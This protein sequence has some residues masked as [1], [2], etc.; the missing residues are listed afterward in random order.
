MRQP[1]THDRLAWSSPTPLVVSKLTPQKHLDIVAA[2][3]RLAL[4]S[5]KKAPRYMQLAKH[6]EEMAKVAEVTI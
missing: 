3:H 6:H 2:L 4:R 5:P 1:P